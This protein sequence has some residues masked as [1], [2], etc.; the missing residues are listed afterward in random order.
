MGVV[1][2]A[3][4]KGEEL[5]VIGTLEEIAE[6]RGVNPRTIYNYSLP[7]HITRMEK[8][9]KQQSHKLYAERVKRGVYKVFDD[10]TLIGE[11]NT[12]ELV[13]Q[14]GIGL[15]KLKN[16]FYGEPQKIRKKNYQIVVRLEG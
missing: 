7:G 12:K 5:L 3:L 8:R 15:E 11:G 14:T 1:E 13:E 2:Y 6:E 4:Y 9:V 16:L 10:N